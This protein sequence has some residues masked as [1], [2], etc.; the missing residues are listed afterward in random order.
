ML[1][2]IFKI[3]SL[4]LMASLNWAGFSAVFYT[5]AYFDN[6]EESLDNSLQAD[7][8][9]FHLESLEDFS[10][11]I[12][13]DR[14]AVRNISVKNDGNLDFQYTI[15]TS[16]VIGELCDYLDLTVKRDD[17]PVFYSGSLKDFYYDAKQ[18]FN[19]D[20][21]QFTATLGTS[22]AS[23]LG[24]TCSFDFVFDGIQMENTGFSDQEVIPNIISAINVDQPDE[25]A[26]IESIIEE[27]A[28]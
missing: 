12:A 3:V 16:N 1:K 23:L 14:S 13:P 10:P 6:S 22:D 15:Q 26:I 27:P 21:W 11:E 18:F 25:S 20:D 19:P 24:Q 9:D 5:V 4:V 8:L 2:R 17:L 7:T 28:L